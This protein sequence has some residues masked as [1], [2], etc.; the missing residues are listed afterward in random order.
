MQV[1]LPDQM[2]IEL[3]FESAPRVGEKVTVPEDNRTFK[4]ID[5]HHFSR[6]DEA[7]EPTVQ[8]HLKAIAARSGHA[9]R[10]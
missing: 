6:D 7:D 2:P 4:V 3:F 9:S 1:S 10:S 8:I 5:V